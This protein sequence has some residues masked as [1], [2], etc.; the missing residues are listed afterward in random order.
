MFDKQS[1]FFPGLQISEGTYIYILNVQ[2]A[3]SCEEN[4]ETYHQW[5]HEN[6]SDFAQTWVAPNLRPCEGKE[7]LCILKGPLS[8]MKTT[9]NENCLL[10]M[11]EYRVF[12]AS[13]GIFH[14]AKRSLITETRC[15]THFRQV[16]F[17]RFYKENA[18]V[19]QQLG[20]S[21]AGN[22]DTRV[23]SHLK[24]RTPMNFFSKTKAGFEI[25]IPMS[26]CSD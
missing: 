2:R 13:L 10:Y 14:N 5:Y 9:Q 8:V 22:Q 20:C 7:P 23:S 17:N 16:N 18:D 19:T 21:C 3:F 24:S 11:T 25:S 15:N 12:S 6:H 1:I 4:L 26:H